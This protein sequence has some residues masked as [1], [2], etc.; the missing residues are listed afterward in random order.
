MIS[1]E[2]HRLLSLLVIAYALY[3]FAGNV[4]P[5][6]VIGSP[7]LNSTISIEPSLPLSPIQK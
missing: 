4:M 5:D 2:M 1:D 6:Y 3:A 7:F